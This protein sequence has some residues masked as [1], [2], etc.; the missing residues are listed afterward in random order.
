MFYVLI[1]LYYFYGYA[2]VGATAAC[3]PVQLFIDMACMCSEQLNQ[4]KRKKNNNSGAFRPLICLIVV[5]LFM[6][7]AQIVYEIWRNSDGSSW[8]YG[9]IYSAQRLDLFA[10]CVRLSR[11]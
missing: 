5:S 2:T 11:L 3:W 1:S 8:Y 6:I 7:Y 4:M 10:W 9:I